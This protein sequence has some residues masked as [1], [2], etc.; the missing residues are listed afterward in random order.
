VIE[1][2]EGKGTTGTEGEGREV[3]GMGDGG[4]GAFEPVVILD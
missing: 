4:R 2:E 3:G 1:G